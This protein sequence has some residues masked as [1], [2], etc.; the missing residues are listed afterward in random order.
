MELVLLLLAGFLSLAEGQ[1]ECMC[2]NDSYLSHDSC[3][4]NGAVTSLSA[5]YTGGTVI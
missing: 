3:H 1:S 2:F 5:Q 4:F